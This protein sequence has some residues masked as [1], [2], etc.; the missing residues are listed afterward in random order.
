MAGGGIQASWEHAAALYSSELITCTVATA[1]S[2][3]VTC[4]GHTPSCVRLH[5]AVCRSTGAYRCL[6]HQQQK[7]RLCGQHQCHT[8]A[9]QHQSSSCSQTRW[10]CGLAAGAEGS[11]RTQGCL[12]SHMQTLIMPIHD[13]NDTLLLLLQL[14]NLELI[15]YRLLCCRSVPQTWLL[16]SS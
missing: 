8:A 7:F 11:V 13:G 4:T 12:P 2:L 5:A 15:C 10:A 3:S 16:G 14:I 1:A 6:P 9:H